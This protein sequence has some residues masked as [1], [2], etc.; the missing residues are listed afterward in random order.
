MTRGERQEA[1][2]RDSGRQ[3][4]SHI[5]VYNIFHYKLPLFSCPLSAMRMSLFTVEQ[6]R[7]TRGTKG[8]ASVGVEFDNAA[9]T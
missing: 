8:C 6:V 2:V 7:T 3:L 1:H 5:F 9:I 4:P